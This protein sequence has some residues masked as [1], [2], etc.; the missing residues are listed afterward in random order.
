VAGE[1]VV[2]EDIRELAERALR[3]PSRDGGPNPTPQL[4]RFALAVL[5]ALDTEWKSAN[6][7]CA[8][9]DARDVIDGVR[10][11]IARNM[12]ARK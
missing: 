9:G 1:V 4:A 6:Y 8:K 10:V 3:P 12:E 5:D 7:L 2:M 11:A